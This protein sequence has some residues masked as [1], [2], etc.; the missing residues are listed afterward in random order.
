M[1]RPARDID[2]K[3]WRRSLVDHLE[4]YPRQ[5]EALRFSARTFGPDFGLAQLADAFSS[6]EPEL[7]TRVQ[8]IERALGRLQS[9]MAAMAEDGTK[10][11]GLVRRATQDREPRAQPA[12]E[13]LRDAGVI[14]KDICGRIVAS[15]RIRN[16]LE[17]DYVKMDAEDL[18]EAVTQMLKLAPE[19]LD[20]FA[21]WVEPHLV[22]PTPPAR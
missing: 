15:Q 16:R 13:A 9:Y 6:D 4:D 17:H 5:L 14:T 3:R 22:G 10:L 12:F 1:P 20:R 19:F 2:Q 8:A 7:Y 18:H 11:A 21:R